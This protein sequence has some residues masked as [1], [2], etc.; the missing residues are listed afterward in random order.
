MKYINNTIEVEYEHFLL[1]VNYNWRKGN[2]GDYYN[3]PIEDEVDI[4][5]VIIS[6]YINEDG[7]KELIDTQREFE[8]YDLSEAFILEQIQYDVDNWRESLRPL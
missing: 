2:A 5:K 1:E 6:G 3:P 8:M 4:N 7:T